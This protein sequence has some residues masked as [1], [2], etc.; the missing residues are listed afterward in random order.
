M[1]AAAAATH[2]HRSACMQNPDAK[3][4]MRGA[5]AGSMRGGMSM[6]VDAG[7]WTVPRPRSRSCRA[8]NLQPKNVEK[9]TK[10]PNH[11]RPL[12]GR[13]PQPV[14]EPNRLLRYWT[15]PWTLHP[16]DCLPWPPFLFTPHLHRGLNNPR[17][18]PELSHTCV[19]TQLQ[20]PTRSLTMMISSIFKMLDLRP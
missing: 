10:V 7:R 2:R 11:V 14:R 12:L 17:G 5:N 8:E 19:F 3:Q 9:A 15:R 6:L 4:V 16:F 20:L 13:Q 1:G 18:S